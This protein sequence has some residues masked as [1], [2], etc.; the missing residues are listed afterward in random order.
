MT[1]S[2][3]DY[4]TD[5]RLRKALRRDFRIYYY[6]SGS[7]IKSVMNCDKIIVLEDGV[8]TDTNA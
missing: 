5:A 3:L 2:A 8:V 1:P 7:S 6:C 4:I